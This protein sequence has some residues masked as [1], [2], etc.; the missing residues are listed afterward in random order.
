MNTVYKLCVNKASGLNLYISNINVDK[1][2]EKK[3][4]RDRGRGTPSDKTIS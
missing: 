3:Q 4:P 2:K 1:T